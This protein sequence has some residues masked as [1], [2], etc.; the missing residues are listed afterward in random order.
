MSADSSK[1]IIEKFTING[2]IDNDHHLASDPREIDWRTPIK[3]SGILPKYEG[4]LMADKSNISELLNLAYAVHEITD[5]EIVETLQWMMK[6]S[7]NPSR[8]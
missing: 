1:N 6:T 3:D 4:S 5:F 2:M 8:N 7:S